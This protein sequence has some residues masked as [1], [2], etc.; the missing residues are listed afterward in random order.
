[1]HPSPSSI[2]VGGTL[3]LCS[4]LIIKPPKKQPLKKRV[5]VTAGAA[6]GP[7]SR[8]AQTS[9]AS[10]YMNKPVAFEG[11]VM[12]DMLPDSNEYKILKV[13]VETPVWNE[14][15]R[16]A[17]QAAPQQPLPVSDGSKASFFQRQAIQMSQDV[18]VTGRELAWVQKGQRCRF[19]GRWQLSKYGPQVAVDTCKPLVP[20]SVEGKAGMYHL[21]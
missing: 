5:S 10:T 2:A 13:S 14:L 4:S 16:P 3:R 20:E 19:Q 18:M 1:M 15:I 11:L 7:T 9:F 8:P 6:L 12:K 21:C 17:M